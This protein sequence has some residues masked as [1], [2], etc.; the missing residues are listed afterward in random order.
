MVLS[1]VMMNATVVLGIGM[2]MSGCAGAS[3]SKVGED[4]SGN[5]VAVSKKDVHAKTKMSETIFLEP[6]SPERQVIY[7]RFRNTS[8]EDLNVERKIKAKFERMGFRVTRNPDEATFLVQA[9]LLKVGQIDKAEQ[10]QLL[11]Q[12][13]KAGAGLGAG[14]GG[15]SALLGTGSYRDAGTAGL[16]GA[17]GG[18]LLGM[19]YDSMKVED[20][21]YALVTDVEIRQRPLEGETGVQNDGMNNKQGATGHSTQKFVNNNVKWKI[22]RT[23]IVSS[24]Y[25]AGLDFSVAQPFLENGMVRAIAGTM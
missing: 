22:Y 21:H 13:F 23:R 11:G 14:I 9:N 2:L 15:V 4:F 8:D 17:A 10:K 7:F 6:V 19:A 16:I 20:I 12:G 1:K 5:K 18:A 3:F 24:A 25:G